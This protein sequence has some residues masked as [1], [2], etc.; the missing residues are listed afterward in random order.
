MEVHSS[1]RRGSPGMTHIAEL[2]HAD[3]S[4]LA[5]TTVGRLRLQEELS[6]R[7]LFASEEL[8]HVAAGRESSPPV[9]PLQETNACGHS[10]ASG[11][12]CEKVLRASATLNTW[13]CTAP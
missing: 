13:P 11:V 5:D 8:A 12:L 9:E 3:L 10:C 6:Q 4:Q 7:H 1:G 2:H